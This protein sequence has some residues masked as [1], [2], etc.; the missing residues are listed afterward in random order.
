MRRSSTRIARPAWVTVF[1]ATEKLLEALP[2]SGTIVGVVAGRRSVRRILVHGFP[3]SLI[4]LERARTVWIL[5]V[6]H[7]R[8]R[9]GYWRRRRPVSR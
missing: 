9:P 5:A 3:Y 6:A 2:R 8:R 1:R 7:H 4:Y